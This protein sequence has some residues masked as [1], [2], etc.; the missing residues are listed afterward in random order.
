M[1]QDGRT[2]IANGGQFLIPAYPE[3]IGIR[4]TGHPV[5]QGNHSTGKGGTIYETTKGHAGWRDKVTL[6]AADQC[7][8]VDTITAFVK[9]WT[10]FSFNRPKSHYRTGRNAHL[11]RDN[12]PGYPGR[13]PY[14]GDVDKL[15]RAVYDSLTDAGVWADDSL[16]VDE[17][18]R[19][20]WVGEHE[21]A[22]PVEGV[23]IIIEPLPM[24]YT[25]RPI[26]D[27]SW[28]RPE[29][30]DL[31][32]EY[33]VRERDIRLDGQQYAGFKALPAG[34]AL[35]PSHM[36]RDRAIAILAVAVNIPP[37]HLNLDPDSL[38]STWRR[39]RRE[40]HPD[41]NAGDQTAWDQVE[42]AA[43]VLGLL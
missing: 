41:R 3:R 18:N 40:V 23:V 1:T 35:P 14:G 13:A 4:V 24:R 20:F 15:A 30:R 6:A 26:S 7:R 33:D 25:T 34:T 16:V 38:R 43:K 10:R 39:A 9:V 32:I 31:V 19:K 11:L 12:A 22:Q 28:F 27:Q 37:E 2:R 21:L 8:Y 17:R 36:T 5:T 29:S 42:Q